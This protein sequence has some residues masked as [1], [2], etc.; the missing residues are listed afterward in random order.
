MTDSAWKSD[1]VRSRRNAAVDNRPPPLDPLI[2]RSLLSLSAALDHHRTDIEATKARTVGRCGQMH[3]T[4]RAM[5]PPRPPRSPSPDEE[6][7]RCT[8]GQGRSGQRRWTRI[9][10][11]PE[12]EPE[13][14][15]PEA[16]L[17]PR[18][19]WVQKITIPFHSVFVSSWLSI[20]ESGRT[21][22]GKRGYGNLSRP[23]R[24]RA[25]PPRQEA[26][27]VADCRLQTSA[28]A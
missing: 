12:A 19:R 7:R 2:P 16:E 22:E 15:G 18:N 28:A 8:V 4:E 10:F 20:S 1:H 6:N 24:A 11:R 3:E 23:A 25:G 27:P 5:E 14:P 13:S 17:M 9:E 21:P 26:L